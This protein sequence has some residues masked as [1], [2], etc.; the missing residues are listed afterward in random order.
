MPQSTRPYPGKVRQPCFGRLVT[1]LLQVHLA[2]GGAYLAECL[3]EH[4]SFAVDSGSL[5]RAQAPGGCEAVE[6][7]GRWGRHYRRC[8]SSIAISR[9]ALSIRTRLA[10]AS[11]G[12]APAITRRTARNAARVQTA[13]ISAPLKLSV[14]ATRSA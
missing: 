11:S 9:S 13:W 1:E 14:R 2:A 10:S 5:D 8:T 6:I 7:A 3:Y 12:L 4:R